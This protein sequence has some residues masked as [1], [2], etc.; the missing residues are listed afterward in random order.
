MRGSRWFIGMMAGIIGAV[1]IAWQPA[2][3]ADAMRALGRALFYDPILSVDSSTSCG[4]CHQQF[5]AFAHVDHAL[6]HGVQGRVG[7]R[8]VPALQNLGDREAY[9]WDG[10]IEQLDMQ[11]LSP[12]TGHDEMGER[13]EHIVTK[14]QRTTRYPLAMERAYGTPEITAPRVL[15]AL[16]AFVRSLQSRSAR[17]D[18][19]MRG[20]DTLDEFESRGEQLFMQHC[21]ACHGGPDFTDDSYASNG[22]PVDTALRD[23]GRERVTSERTD[24]Y[25][26]RV[27]SLRNVERTPPY[28]HDGRFKRLKDV[29]QFYATPSMR[30]AHADARMRDMPAFDERERKDLLAFLLT[31]TDHRFLADTTL[32]DPWRTR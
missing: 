4:T 25:R 26:F 6:S 8:N 15:R 13:L 11:A 22:L 30:A 7:R 27:P 9:M 24:R 28:M 12:L 29:L 14:L 5:A 3:D 17:Y 1:V 23:V 32:S 20:R 16:G 2:D 21:L 18:M 31:L 19:V 10:A